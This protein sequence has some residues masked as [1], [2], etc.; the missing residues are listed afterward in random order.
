MQPHFALRQQCPQPVGVGPRHQRLGEAQAIRLG[1]AG[2]LGKGVGR[3]LHLRIAIMVQRTHA[4]RIVENDRH[5]RPALTLVP[6]AQLRQER[7]ASSSTSRP[8][9]RPAIKSR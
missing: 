1:D 3:G 2:L 4:L 8:R 7:P 6:D 9:R 5:V